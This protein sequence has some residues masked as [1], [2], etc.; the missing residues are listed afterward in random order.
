M[1]R[2][3]LRASR[4]LAASRGP[5]VRPTTPQ[6]LGGIAP[7]LPTRSC[8]L[9]T[10]PSTVPSTAAAGTT[11]T[12]PAATAEGTPEPPKRPLSS[13]FLFCA[14]LRAKTKTEAAAAGVEPKKLGHKDLKEAW[15]SLPENEK[16]SYKTT[17]QAAFDVYKEEKQAFETAHPEL[18]KKTSKKKK[19][20]M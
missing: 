13:F 20:S 12:T 14:D 19:T 16:T 17:A 8:G 1:L 9:A 3:A 2:A 7:V 18:A 11:T 6:G 5:C 10:A 15:D 4:P